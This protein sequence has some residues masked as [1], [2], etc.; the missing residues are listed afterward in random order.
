MYQSV[1]D[2]VIDLLLEDSEESSEKLNELFA[3]DPF[4]RF[5]YEQEKT[6]ILIEKHINKDIT[7]EESA[8]LN[9]LIK[10]DP[11]LVNEINLS[12]RV[13]FFTENLGFITALDKANEQATHD[14]LQE[15]QAIRRKLIT[16]RLRPVIKWAVAASVLLFLGIMGL[17]HI[18]DNEK[19]TGP[20]LYAA[21][22]KPVSTE[23]PDLYIV[24]SNVLTAA[25]E[26]YFSSDYHGAYV[27]LKNLPES[28]Y[29]K[30]EKDFYLALSCMEIG[31]FHNA[32]ALFEGILENRNFEGINHVYWYLGLCHLKIE[33]KESAISYLT[34]VAKMDRLNSSKAKK[35]ISSLN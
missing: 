34:Q 26:K 28:L 18:P 8:E 10:K 2:I 5:V 11:S 6:K 27:S 14:E 22:Y 35:I 32:I 12:R 23:V 33:D 20:E 24:T 19:L 30:E 29:I 17:Q 15:Y 16:V 4:A 7:A 25:K 1:R 13:N 9:E 21:Y 31:Y 3:E